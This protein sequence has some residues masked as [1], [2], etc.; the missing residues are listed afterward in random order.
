MVAHVLLAA[1]HNNID[2]EEALER[3]WYKYL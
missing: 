3:K 1:K 2:I